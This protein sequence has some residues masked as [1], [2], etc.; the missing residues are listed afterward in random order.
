MPKSMTFLRVF[1]ASPSDLLEERKLLEGVITEFNII[2]GD[3]H[4][5]R[6]ELIKWETHTRPGFGDD[7]QDVINK[8]VG[9]DYDIFIGMMWCR[10]G[11]ATNRAD[12]GT[13]EEFERAFARFK[14]SRGSVQI[15]FYFKDANLPPSQ[16]DPDQLAKVKAFKNKLS[17]EYG[18]LYH[19]FDSADDFRTKLRIHLSKVV[20]DCLKAPLA[21]TKNRIIDVPNSSE[22]NPLANFAALTNDDFEDGIFELS[23]RASDAMENVTSVVEHITEGIVALGDKIHVRTDELNALQVTGSQPDRRALKRVA[24]GAADDLELYVM[25]LSVDLPEFHKEHS[26]AMELFGKIAMLS[27]TDLNEPIGNVKAAL[28]NL[29]GFRSSI[30]KACEHLSD[31]REAIA[32]SPRMTTAYNRARRR[33]VAIM[34][35]LLS[36][37]RIAEGQTQE[38]EQVLQRILENRAKNSLSLTAMESS[39]HD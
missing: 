19:Q 18:G 35:D 38:V 21:V 1:V 11:L 17:S 39:N 9:D 25:R 23:E 16:I 8:Q 30:V 3:S 34:D 26:L 2:S 20:Q 27:G 31:F 32:N 5:V 7:P 10:F 24:D 4:G 36:V 37:F 14:S 12:S 15:M 33:G 6:L 28:G 29:Q 13:E 22:V